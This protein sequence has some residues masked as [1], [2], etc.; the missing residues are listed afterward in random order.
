MTNNAKENRLIRLPEVQRLTG[1]KRSQLYTLAQRDEF[2]RPIKLSE[3]CSAWLESAVRDW[4]SDRIDANRDP[5]LLRASGALRLQP[6]DDDK[7]NVGSGGLIGA[8]ALA[9]RGNATKS[10]ANGQQ[11]PQSVRPSQGDI[12]S[13]NAARRNGG[14]EAR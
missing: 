10:R 11:R 12:S 6:T 2:P 14:S 3:R 1:L 9:A 8:A 5:A 7:P 13:A 4:I